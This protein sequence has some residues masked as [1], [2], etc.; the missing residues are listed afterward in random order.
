MIQKREISS[1][2][3]K[4]LD[5]VHFIRAAKSRLVSHYFSRASERFPVFSSGTLPKPELQPDVSQN[6]RCRLSVTQA[7]STPSFNYSPLPPPFLP[8]LGKQM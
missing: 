4:L 8:P 7:T 2:I 5:E 1:D 3:S 6:H